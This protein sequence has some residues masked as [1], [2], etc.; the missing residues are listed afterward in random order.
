[1]ILPITRDG[2]DWQLEM[3]IPTFAKITCNSWNG[4]IDFIHHEDGLQKNHEYYYRGHASE[5]WKLESTL[6][7]QFNHEIPE[8]IESKVLD[9]FKRYCLGRRGHNPAE[10]NENEWWAL[11][12]HFGLHTPL[13]DWTASPFIAAFFAFNSNNHDTDN[14]AIWVLS[15]HIMSYPETSNLEAHD[16]IDFLS[17]Y[18]NENARLINQRG[19]FTKSPNMVCI[20]GWIKEK[21]K[22]NTTNMSI[23]LAKIIIPTK[24]K[25]L[26]L[27]SLD[28]MN[29]N[30]LTLFPDLIGAASFAN[31]VT[32][33]DIGII[34]L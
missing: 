31:Y 1:M 22:S 21:I 3:A 14:V 8:D 20:E 9:N 16:K 29:I 33:R 15:K 23:A 13:L 28:K 26:A 32:E 30:S 11:G 17:P 27:D 24:E 5:T 18:L 34:S 7:R 19:L 2:N 25:E 6:K 12:Q 4:F 10:L